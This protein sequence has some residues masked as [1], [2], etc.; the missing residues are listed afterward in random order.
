MEMYLLIDLMLFLSRERQKGF[1]NVNVLIEILQNTKMTG[2]RKRL[3]IITGLRAVG[4]Y[5][6]GYSGDKV[7]PDVIGDDTIDLSDVKN[8]KLDSTPIPYQ[9]FNCNLRNGSV[10]FDIVLN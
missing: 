6:I 2:F 8:L 10:R 5:E 1:Q 3:S 4:L 9:V 7:I